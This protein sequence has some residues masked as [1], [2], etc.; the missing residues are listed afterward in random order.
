M[1]RRLLVVLALCAL[2]LREF[3]LQTVLT[4]EMEVLVGNALVTSAII[5]LVSVLFISVG[6]RCMGRGSMS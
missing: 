5:L 6:G 4:G 3:A 2:V 1:I